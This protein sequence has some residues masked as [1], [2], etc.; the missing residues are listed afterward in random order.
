MCWPLPQ[1]LTPTAGGLVVVATYRDYV[2]VRKLQFSFPG[3]FPDGRSLRDTSLI[4]KTLRYHFL[5][6]GDRINPPGRK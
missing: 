3:F 4:Q 1:H 5:K 2:G 6:V